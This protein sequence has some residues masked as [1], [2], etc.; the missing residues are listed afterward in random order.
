MVFD[1]PEGIRRKIFEKVH[2]RK[3]ALFHHL[4]RNRPGFRHRQHVNHPF[5]QSIGT[6]LYHRA[7]DLKGKTMVCLL[8]RNSHGDLKYSRLGN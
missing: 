4:K 3:G 6:D 2:H 1:L 5:L 8:G 7:N